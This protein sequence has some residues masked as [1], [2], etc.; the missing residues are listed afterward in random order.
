MFFLNHPVTRCGT[1]NSR[2]T[3]VN[4]PICLPFPT[5][6]YNLRWNQ[7]LKECW[8][9]CWK[10]AKTGL[11]VFENCTL[12]VKR[13]FYLYLC[14][15]IWKTAIWLEK[16]RFICDNKITRAQTNFLYKCPFL[17]VDVLQKGLNVCIRDG[18]DGYL[19]FFCE[20]AKLIVFWRK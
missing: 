20:R 12:F 4:R 17:F 3:V 15:L 18:R 5:K 14:W 11:K 1:A 16:Q 10:S 8:K 6:K 7:C 2:W 13:S 19:P 9:E